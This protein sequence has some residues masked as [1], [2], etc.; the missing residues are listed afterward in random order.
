[1]QARK[2]LFR[3]WVAMRLFV[4]GERRRATRSWRVDPAIIDAQVREVAKQLRQAT[5]VNFAAAM[6]VAWLFFDIPYRST[7][8]LACGAL[9]LLTIGALFV[10]PHA[11]WQRTRFRDVFEE[12]RALLVH[13]F[14]TGL[15]WGGMMLAPLITATDINR[16]YIFAAMTASM[17][18]GGLILAM[19]PAAAMLYTGVLG[20]GMMVA[21][22]IQPVPVPDSMYAATVLYLFML[23][24]VFF[25]LGNLFIGQMKA[26]AE[27][28]RAESVKR[29]EQRREMER[30]A[31]ERL[32]A[33][34]ERQR[35]LAAEQSTHRDELLRLAESFEASVMAVA[36][37]LESA[38]GNVNSASTQLHDI[39]RDA[40]ARA[41]AASDRATSASRAV[42]GVAIASGEMI[43]AVGHVSARV[44]EQ[45]E[46]S[47]AARA[48]AGDTRRALE[49]LA[50]SAQ[51]IAHVATFIQDVAAN[52]NLLALNAT[53]EAARAG[54]AGRGF[55]V[56]A[57]EVKS[58][59]TQTGAAIE[60]IGATT[61]AIQG[62]VADAMAAV[63]KAAA[64]VESVS[65]RAG[66]IAEAVTQ[67][68]QASDM[69][70]RNASD[71][72][73]DAEDVHANI[74]QVAERARE[75]GALTDSMRDLAKSLDAQSRALT[76][77]AG[78]FLS[79]LRAA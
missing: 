5:P 2:H 16:T 18:V 30:R 25:D 61:T 28:G 70:G 11:P 50:A 38:V 3:F 60:K 8:L 56:V 22:T 55:A 71:A 58:L 74:A 66:A 63:E 51:D 14:A 47:V 17:C 41:S 31:A 57:Q 59:A 13:A 12:R 62:R 46:A 44:A 37:G 10:L 33:E 73:E 69:I 21:Y 67:Q 9:M 19:L 34:E 48:S 78:D 7:L 27:L 75:T 64:Q 52:T 45:V 65:Y 6:L 49:E 1:M 4:R 42:A 53:I 79:R 39:G 23:A 68:R 32:Q 40:D 76:Q 15:A 54:E 35:V 72:A 24:R 36:R 43:Q 77:A 26:T 29:E 20:I